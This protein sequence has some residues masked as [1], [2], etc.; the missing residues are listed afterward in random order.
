VVGGSERQWL[1]SGQGRE[2]LRGG[3][4]GVLSVARAWPHG[5]WPWVVVGWCHP[6]L[7][8]GKPHRR[9]ANGRQWQTSNQPSN[10]AFKRDLPNRGE[11]QNQSGT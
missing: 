3:V 7:P 9:V 11:S 1:G 10:M 4:A 2:L 5:D 6:P 8:R